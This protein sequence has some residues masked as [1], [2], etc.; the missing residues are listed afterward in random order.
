M[1]LLKQPPSEGK[2]NKQWLVCTSIPQ[3]ISIIFPGADWGIKIREP[4]VILM[5]LPREPNKG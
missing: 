1:E 3:R 4:L 5:V 2:K